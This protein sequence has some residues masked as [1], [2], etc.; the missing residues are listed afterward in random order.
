MTEY[1]EYNPLDSMELLPI[2][3]EN[4]LTLTEAYHSGHD[5]LFFE[6]LSKH[7]LDLEKVRDALN[8]AGIGWGQ[9]MTKIIEKL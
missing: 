2:E 5:H 9:L 8:D 4:K 3:K 1:P 6:N 7:I